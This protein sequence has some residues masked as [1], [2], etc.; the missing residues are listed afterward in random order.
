M[1]DHGKARRSQEKRPTAANSHL[2]RIVGM[3]LSAYAIGPESGARRY[4]SLIAQRR[5]ADHPNTADGAGLASPPERTPGARASKQPRRG[6]ADGL[7][8]RREPAAAGC[9][10]R[11]SAEPARGRGA[12]ASLR[13]SLSSLDLDAGACILSSGP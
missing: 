12:S 1:V 10:A 11:T 3:T 2:N 9:C 8:F 6:R 13:R 5:H 7:L 4:A